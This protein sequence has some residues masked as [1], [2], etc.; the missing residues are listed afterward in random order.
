MA[1]TR[2]LRTPR[3]I[4]Q[5]MRANGL[6]PRWGNVYPTEVVVTRRSDRQAVSKLIYCAEE[7]QNMS[8]VRPEEICGA[9]NRDGDL[10]E[11]SQM[12]TMVKAEGFVVVTIEKY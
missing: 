11:P 7:V 6:A 3:D 1:P 12:V 4:S 8:Y 10:G 9:S 5:W 2:I